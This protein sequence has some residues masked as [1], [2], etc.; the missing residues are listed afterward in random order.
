MGA[1]KS[2]DFAVGDRTEWRG[3]TGRQREG[4]KGRKARGLIWEWIRKARD[5]GFGVLGS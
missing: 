2:R 5:L 3:V 1:M 4:R